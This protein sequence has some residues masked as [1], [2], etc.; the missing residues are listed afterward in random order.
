VFALADPDTIRLLRALST[1][2]PATVRELAARLASDPTNV[3]Q[4]IRQGLA[5]G[6]VCVLGGELERYAIVPAVV[7]AAV[8]Q[9]RDCLL[10]ATARASTAG[11]VTG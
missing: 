11:A 8:V 7:E 6:V 10:G 3:R 1:E 9:H 4:T 5:T 2:G